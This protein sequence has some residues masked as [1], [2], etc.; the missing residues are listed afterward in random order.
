LGVG[1]EGIDGRRAQRRAEER[2]RRTFRRRQLALLAGVLV[3]GGGAYLA[4]SSGGGGSDKPAPAKTAVASNGSPA[5]PSLVAQ[6]SG[7]QMS[8]DDAR[9]AR[10]P[11]LM[12]H[13]ISVP[14][15]G[16]ASLP[17]LFV[18]TA[19][20]KDQMSYL[21]DQ[22]Y[23]AVTLDQVWSAW[24]GKG[25]LPEKPIVLS[26]DD[27]YLTQYT[28]AA[29]VLKE[30]GWPGVLNLK[31][32]SLEQGEMTPTMNKKMIG[33]GWEIDSHTINH[34][35]VSQLSGA[36]LKHEV[37]DSRTMLQKE[38]GIPVNFFCYPAGAN[39]PESIAAVKQAGYLGATTVEPGLAAPDEDPDKLPRIRI[40]GSDSLDAFKQKLAT[41]S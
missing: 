27:G 23:E 33:A 35:D 11:I 9:K 17:E 22:G 30:M 4:L 40:S 2:R 13:S 16:G 10:V 24:Q 15:Q 32:L 8:A 37:G 31:L 7:P 6:P 18:P 3:V 34:L 21:S 29:P 38:F 19:N 36:Q 14:P 41:A 1:D 5:K 12:Y 28:H 25:P 20:F 39:D 26:F